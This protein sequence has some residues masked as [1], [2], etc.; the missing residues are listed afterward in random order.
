MRRRKGEGRRGRVREKKAGKGEMH[1]VFQEEIT[2][3]PPRTLPSRT[4]GAEAP[5]VT[6]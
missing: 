1:Y 3:H 5:P 4:E 6:F 2:N